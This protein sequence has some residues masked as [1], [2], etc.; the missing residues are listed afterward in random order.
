MRILIVTSFLFPRGGDSTYSFSLGK[1]LESM[2]HEVF[3][4]GMKH[5]SNMKFDYSSLFVESIDFVS[6]NNNKSIVTGLKVIKRAI[7]STESKIKISEY[8]KIVRPDLVH[9]NSIHG[10]ITPSIIP[11]IKKFHIPIVWTLHDFRLLCPNTH[12]LSNGKNCEKCKK[13]RFYYCTL[14]KCKKQSFLSS[15]VASLDAYFYWLRPLENQV[16]YFI[17]P[18]IF[19]KTKM[20]EYV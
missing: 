4:W 20:I 18:S 15:L 10:H 7:Y 9:L 12:F 3:F 6:L 8:L 19:L 2:G 17:S 14:K 11:A 16:D 1:L 5:E 13:R